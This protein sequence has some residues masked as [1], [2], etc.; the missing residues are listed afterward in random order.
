MVVQTAHSIGLFK[1]GTQ[2]LRL[3]FE[4]EPNALGPLHTATSP[5]P[6]VLP[7][8]YLNT[9]HILRTPRTP[10]ILHSP[11]GPFTALAPLSLLAPLRLVRARG[12][13]TW[14]LVAQELNDAIASNAKGEV[15][16]GGFFSK[17]DVCAHTCHR[18]T[19]TEEREV[20]VAWPR[21]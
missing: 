11:L 18:E 8:H 9:P 20:L 14:T 5:P 1:E 15:G 13:H 4:F 19:C 7:H 17:C 6:I 10:N 21:T 2:P 3:R 12:T 16:G